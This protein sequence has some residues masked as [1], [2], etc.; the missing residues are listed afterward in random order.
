MGNDRLGGSRRYYFLPNTYNLNQGG[1]WFGNSNGS[2]QN[3]Y[4][5]GAT[6]GALGNPAITWERAKKYDVGLEVHFFED[7]LS[8][9]G[10][11]F[12]E[13]RNN[14]LT[15][16][17]TIPSVYGVP[18]S[19]V[20]PANVGITKN[21]GWE[22]M[23]RWEDHVRDLSYSIEGN[24][25]YARNKIIYRAEANNPY[26]WM[27]QTGYSIGQR[28]GLTS[29]GLYNTLEELNN[30]PY[31]TYTSN[32]ATLG[33]VK[34]KD[35]NGDGLIDSKDNAP[36]GYPNYPE[37]HF[38]TKV[39][40]AYKGFD[41]NV[42][43]TG[44]ANGSYYLSSGYTI[45]FFKR[46]GNAWQWMYDGRWTEEKYLAG[47]EINYPRSTFD[48]NGTHNNYLQSDYWMKSNNFIKIKNIELGYTFKTEKSH[49]LSRI[50][51]L[52]IYANANNV[53]TFRN[54]LSDIGIDPETSDGRTYIYPL[55]SVV[56]LGLNLQF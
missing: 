53:Y 10:D 27:N 54:K 3:S 51:A 41:L 33:D 5:S 1:Y 26:P 20:P 42:L 49:L 13:D 44:T 30:R 36:I 28:F 14:I 39:K 40:L 46:A 25:N 2:S 8:L 9:V 50:S 48:A 11:W 17:G 47:E 12:K 34:Y 23:F 16:L 29:D 18:S 32:R 15:T 55:T 37:Y 7:R 6:E 43:F 22:F 31:N 4:Y 21:E 19:S 38:S 52:R 45:P 24:I 35:L 56:T